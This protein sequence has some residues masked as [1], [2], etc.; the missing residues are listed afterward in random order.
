LGKAQYLNK[1][2]GTSV[3]GKETLTSGFPNDLSFAIAK[4]GREKV[5]F[6]DKGQIGINGNM[7]V[8]MKILANAYTIGRD[9]H[10]GDTIIGIK[11]RVGFEAAPLM[12]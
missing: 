2:W 4:K 9:T 11:G 3:G 8:S 1:G 10:V 6:F 12:Q 5:T 7:D